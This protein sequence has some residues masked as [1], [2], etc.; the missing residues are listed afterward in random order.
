MKAETLT[1]LTVVLI[2]AVVGVCAETSPAQEVPRIAK[3]ELKSMLGN[4]DTIILDV[5]P[6]EQWTRSDRKI[7][8]ALH[9]DPRHVKSWAGKYP[10]DKILVLY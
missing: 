4:P 6:V 1:I 8:G 3:E 5:R 7:P 10:K 9:E 2:V